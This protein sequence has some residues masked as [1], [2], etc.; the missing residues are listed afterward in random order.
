MAAG[1]E[2]PGVIEFAA[3]TG[4]DTHDFPA[5]SCEISGIDT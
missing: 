2:F 1:L 5:T 3:E 4:V